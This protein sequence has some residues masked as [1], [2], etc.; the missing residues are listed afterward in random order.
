MKDLLNNDPHYET[1]D[2]QPYSS[3]D[4]KREIVN[5]DVD[6]MNYNSMTKFMLLN[7]KVVRKKNPNVS[8]V[9]AHSREQRED[10]L[11]RDML[12]IS[13]RGASQLPS[14]TSANRSFI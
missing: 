8:A 9:K 14:Y 4:H 11:A 3:F 13:Q 12:L 1:L 5:K 10:E 6:S 2:K 7:C